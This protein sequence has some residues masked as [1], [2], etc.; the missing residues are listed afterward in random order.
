MSTGRGVQRIQRLAGCRA[1][2]L[3]ERGGHR[4]V[5]RHQPFGVVE[6]GVGHLGGVA[7]LADF[8]DE[9]LQV[10]LIY[11]RAFLE[12]RLSEDQLRHFRQEASGNGLSSYPHPWLMPNFWQ[13]PTVSMG[14]GPMMAIYQAR[15]Q[16]YM[17]NREMVPASDRKIWAF[18][19]DGEMDEPESMGALTLL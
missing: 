12:G 16:R 6:D 1:R 19:G 7:E 10:A 15:F 8:L 14:L 3:L 11:A 2:R 18:L 13:F 5:H 9:G 17:E 4:E